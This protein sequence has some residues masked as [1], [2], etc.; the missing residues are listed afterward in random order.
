ML[1][2]LR[3]SVDQAIDSFIYF[4]KNVFGHPRLFHVTSA[5]F[6]P[7][8]KYSAVKACEA[9]KT[10]I[11]SRVHP[12]V[13]DALSLK[14]SAQRAT[15]AEAGGGT[16]TIA[17]SYH[18]KNDGER[19]H[20]WRGYYNPDSNTSWDHSANIWEVALATFATPSYFDAIEINEFYVHSETEQW[21][22]LGMGLKKAYRLSG[23]EGN[24]QTIP[25]DDWRPAATGIKTLQE[26]TDITKEYLL[27]D[28]VRDIINSIAHE[29][30]RIRRAR[31]TTERWKVFT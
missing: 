7:R 5:C 18:V 6:R 30:V 11:T 29:A 14:L 28:R 27:N 12:T 24:L 26:I 9:I 8:A 2:R 16:R 31:A 13:R 15:F 3:M 1:G 20:I 19:A 25:Y 17:I 23:S 4:S 21:L 10:I 22:E